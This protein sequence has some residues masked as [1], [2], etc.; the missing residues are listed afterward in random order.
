MTMPY[1]SARYLPPDPIAPHDAPLSVEATDEQ[2]V[3]WVLQEN[4]E[5][6][7]WIR[8]LENGGIITSVV[9]AVPRAEPDVPPYGVP[10]YE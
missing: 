10:P 7:D 9:P 3:K 5:V 6:G 1:V 2:G 8:Y 4:S